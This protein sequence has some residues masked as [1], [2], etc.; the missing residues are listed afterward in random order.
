MK[1][2]FSDFT[3]RQEVHDYLVE[4][5]KK[6][7]IKIESRLLDEDG[8]VATHSDLFLENCGD[9]KYYF[10]D[11]ESLEINKLNTVI[12]FVRANGEKLIVDYDECDDFEQK[13][14]SLINS[15]L[16]LGFKVDENKFSCK[17]SGYVTNDQ[18]SKLNS[19]LDNISK[20]F[21]IKVMLE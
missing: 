4:N 10:E 17:L 13:C 12:L 14:I 18:L 19:Y 9:I 2:S 16:G 3:S 11:D 8:V 6:R 21:N 7:V 15:E 1:V 5:S 20:E